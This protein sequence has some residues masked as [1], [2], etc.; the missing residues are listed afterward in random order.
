MMTKTMLAM[1][2]A[3]AAFF[4]E[5]ALWKGLDEANRYSGPKLDESDLEGKVVMVDKWGVACPPCRALLPKMESYWKAFK[6]RGFVLIGSH[7][8]GR[9]VDEVMALVKEHALT[10]PVYDGVGLAVDE[11]T[12]KAIPFVYV[13]NHRGKVVYAGHDSNQA[14]QIAQDAI[15]AMSMPPSLTGDVVLDNKSPYRKYEKQLVLGKNVSSVVK[16]L[17]NDVKK[18]ERRA[19]TAAQKA[20]AQVARALLAAIE[21]ARKDIPAEIER[22]K[23]SNPEEA[24]AILKNYVKS[25]P[26]ESAELKAQIPELTKRAAEW[27]KERKA[28]AAKTKKCP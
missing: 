4:A 12:S 20:D 22:K 3:T 7:C 1:L 8:Q 9:K 14:I 17:E 18:S 19:A 6:G 2:V 25:F 11:P 24:L 27:K 5:A 10:F 16:A 21:E 26:K 23:A 28:S 15:L 13:V